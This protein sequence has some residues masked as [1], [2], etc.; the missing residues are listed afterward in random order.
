MDYI[1]VIK[2]RQEIIHETSIKCKRLSSI[3][4]VVKYAQE[5]I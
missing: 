1:P 3:T 5:L 2:L 4:S